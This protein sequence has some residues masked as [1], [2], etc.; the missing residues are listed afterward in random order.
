[1]A[2]SQVTEQDLEQG[3]QSLGGFGKLA[4][5]KPRRDSP[6]GSDFVKRSESEGRAVPA[7][8]PPKSPEIA[9]VPKPL[10][11]DIEEREEV[12]GGMLST[13]SSPS[14]SAPKQLSKPNIGES[15]VAHPKSNTLTDRV[16]LQLS[17]EMRDEV[18]EIARRL[19]RKKTDKKSERTTTN[20]VMRVA[21]QF[22]LDELML[23]EKDRP[24]SEEE[25][26]ELVKA[27]LG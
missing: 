23:E 8:A 17:P 11:Q 3:L 21:I 25:L 6:F 20:T 4:A 24:N 27:K 18:C 7:A 19:Q 5:Q 12:G 15:K 16:T 2:K 10:S 13:K 22:L 26:L 14:T 1:M 9:P